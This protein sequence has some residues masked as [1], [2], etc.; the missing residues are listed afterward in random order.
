MPTRPA[1]QQARVDCSFTSLDPS[2]AE[3]ACTRTE[4]HTGD[5]FRVGEIPTPPGKQTCPKGTRTLLDRL[6]PN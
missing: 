1:R 6:S 2:L 5:V 3:G 4:G